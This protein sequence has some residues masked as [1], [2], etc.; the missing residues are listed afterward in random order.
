[1]R[2][3]TLKGHHRIKTIN[4]QKACNNDTFTSLLWCDNVTI[5]SCRDKL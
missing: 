4:N 2:G 1:M 3:Q 5:Y